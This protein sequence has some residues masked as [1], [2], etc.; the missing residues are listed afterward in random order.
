MVDLSNK[1]EWAVEDMIDLTHFYDKLSK[2]NFAV[3][4]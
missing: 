2:E 3:Q 1:R 4:F